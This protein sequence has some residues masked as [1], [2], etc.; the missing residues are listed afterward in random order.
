MIPQKAPSKNSFISTPEK[1]VNR[2]IS[3]GNVL[4]SKNVPPLY[5]AHSILLPPFPLSVNSLSHLLYIY[6][7]S[8]DFSSYIPTH[9]NFITKQDF[10]H[11]FFGGT[12]SPRNIV[13]EISLKNNDED[14][15]NLEDNLSCIYNKHYPRSD[16][17]NNSSSAASPVSSLYTTTISY[18]DPNPYLSDEVKIKK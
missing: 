8:V 9:T 6:P 10:S 5:I 4:L 13:I 17:S 15:C 18:H 3:S 16:Y 2:E 11:S 1:N 12:K 14:L 7:K